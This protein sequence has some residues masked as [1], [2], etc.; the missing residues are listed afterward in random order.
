MLDLY[1]DWC[2]SCIEMEKFAFSD[3]AVARKMSRFLLVRADVTKNTPAD[4]ALLKRFRLLGPPG[5]I[6]FDAQGKPLNDARVVGFHNASQFSV[7]PHN[8]LAQGANHTQPGRHPW[9]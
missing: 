5:L 2:V 4:R 1:A 9:R 6:F 3:P 8:V 7:V